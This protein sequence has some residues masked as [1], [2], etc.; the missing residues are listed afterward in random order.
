M[1]PW[2]NKLLYKEVLCITND[3]LYPSNSK[4]YGEEP[5]Y[6]E[7]L[8]QLTNFASPLALCYIKVPLYTLMYTKIIAYRV[9]YIS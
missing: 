5:W 7:T 1:E 8:L 6:N 3:F 4:I 9:E 2:Y